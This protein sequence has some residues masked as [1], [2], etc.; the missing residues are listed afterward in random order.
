MARTLSFSIATRRTIGWF[1]ILTIV[2]FYAALYAMNYWLPLGSINHTSRIWNWSQT[3]LTAGACLTLVL[4]G[5]YL[6]TQRVLLGFVL[7]ALSTLSHWLHDPSLLWS[8]LEGVGVWACFLA[9]VILFKDQEASVS[10]FQPPLAD[11]GKSILFGIMVA[12]PLAVINNLYF[13]MN[14]GLLHLQNVF[15][16]AF[17]ALSPAIHEEI[18]FRFFILAITLSLLKFSASRQWATVIAILLAV[19]P[20]SLNHLPELFLENPTMGLFMLIATSLLF[21]LPMAILQMK[22]NLE[23]AISFHWFIDFARFFFGF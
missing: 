10:A 18:I 6:T 7:A 19:I 1:G 9:G 15:Y 23:T 8:L 5:R 2:L 20:H 14:A 13:Y 22:R 3:A 11:L 12:I 17:E 4:Q 16:S 21:G